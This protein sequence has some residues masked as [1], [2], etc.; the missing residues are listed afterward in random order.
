MT[1]DLRSLSLGLLVAL[2]LPAVSAEA[3]DLRKVV[4]KP[5]ARATLAAS[6]GFSDRMSRLDALMG[7]A[8]TARP[9]RARSA[10]A[11]Q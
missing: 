9:A 10:N 5:Q 1:T 4:D 7:G 3:R 2:A 8:P 6:Q 11:E